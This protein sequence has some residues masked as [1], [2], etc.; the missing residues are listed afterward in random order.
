MNS[1]TKKIGYFLAFTLVVLLNNVALAG[2][3]A[4]PGVPIDG[5]LSALIALGVGYGAKQLLQNENEEL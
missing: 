3:P 4:P 5:G 2:P 1:R